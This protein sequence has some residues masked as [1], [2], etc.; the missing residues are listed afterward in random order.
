MLD[1]LIIIIIWFGDTVIVSHLNSYLNWTH[2]KWCNIETSYDFYKV[3]VEDCNLDMS[4][5]PDESGQNRSR[6]CI[7][8]IHFWDITPL[9]FWDMTLTFH[10]HERS[11]IIVFRQAICEFV[12]VFWWN[13]F[14]ISCHFQNFPLL[15]FKVST[16]VPSETP[17]VKVHNVFR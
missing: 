16:F 14:S 3:E 7:D 15:R 8:Y 13:K 1:A 11:N 17:Q 10:G 2:E 5:D 4:C 12:I 6:F 9:R